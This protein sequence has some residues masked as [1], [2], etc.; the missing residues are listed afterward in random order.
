MSF[1]RATIDTLHPYAPGRQP[2]PGTRVIKLN[3]NENPYAPSPRALDVLRQLDVD[4]LRRYPHP[5]ADEF[6]EAVGEVLGV[7]PT[8][9]L[10]G[11]GSDDLLTMLVRAVAGPGRPGEV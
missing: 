4:R 6:R 8:W 2:V 1:F 9:V 7:D 11:N 3:T 10:P 5:F